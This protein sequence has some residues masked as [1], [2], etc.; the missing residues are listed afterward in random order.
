MPRKVN[1]YDNAP[2]ES[3][4]GSLGNEMLHRQRDATQAHAE[5]AI[6]EY[7]EVFHNRQRRQSSLGYVSPTSFVENFRKQA[8]AA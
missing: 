5:A 3:F 8:L 6:K 2:I 7:I 4:S 1:Y